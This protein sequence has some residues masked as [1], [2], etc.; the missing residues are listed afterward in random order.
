[1]LE[2][3]SVGPGCGSVAVPA[4]STYAGL[5]GLGHLG[6]ACRGGNLDN[7]HLSYEAAVVKNGSLAALSRQ[8]CSGADPGHTSSD[9]SQPSFST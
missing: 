8:A 4:R 3:V 9:R 6:H 5:Y 1:M 2:R 7:I